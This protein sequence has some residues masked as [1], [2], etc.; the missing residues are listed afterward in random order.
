MSTENE[1][2]KASEIF[3]TALNRML[4]GNA[5]PLADIWLHSSTVTSMHPI[6]GR[7][8]G[9]WKLIHH[10]TDTSPAMLDVISRL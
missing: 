5:G 10:H 7:E 2:R 9:T 1:V 4:N 6:G 3:Y 8:A